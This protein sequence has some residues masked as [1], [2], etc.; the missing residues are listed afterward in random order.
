MSYGIDDWLEASY[1]DR[2]GEPEMD[3]GTDYLNDYYEDE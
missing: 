2:S 1:E 3:E